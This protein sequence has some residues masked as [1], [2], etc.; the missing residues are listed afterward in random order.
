MLRSTKGTGRPRKLTAAQEAQVFR[1]V[2]GKRPDQNGFDFGLW[3]RQIVQEVLVLRFE[4]KL[5]LA[6]I[7]SLLTRLG[8]TALKPQQRAYQRDPEALP[9]RKTETFPAIAADRALVKSFFRH[10]FVSYISDL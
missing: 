10:P 4:I 8:L 5:S 7:G 6:S 3:T 1:W 2:N 9:R